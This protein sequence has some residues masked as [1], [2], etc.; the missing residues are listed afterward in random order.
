MSTP[1]IGARA[2]LR[3]VPKRK[4]PSGKTTLRET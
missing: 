2:G 1:A 3:T 4:N